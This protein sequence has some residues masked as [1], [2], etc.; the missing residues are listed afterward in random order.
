MRATGSEAGD[1]CYS[2]SSR[3]P[4]VGWKVENTSEPIYNFINH[5]N[6]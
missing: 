6:K 1:I 2:P 5:L 3:K 4:E